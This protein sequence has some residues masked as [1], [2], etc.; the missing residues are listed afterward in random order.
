MQK[1]EGL[2]EL[3]DQQFLEGL[4][5]QLA[6]FQARLKIEIRHKMSLMKQVASL[7]KEVKQLKE[8]KDEKVPAPTPKKKVAPIKRNLI[9]DT[10]EM[11]VIPESN[12]E[13]SPMKECDENGIEK[14]AEERNTDSKLLR[15]HTFHHK[16]MPLS[17]KHGESDDEFRR[18][19]QLEWRRQVNKGRKNFLYESGHELD[20]SKGDPADEDDVLMESRFLSQSKNGGNKSTRSKGASHQIDLLEENL[21]R[22]KMTVIGNSLRVGMNVSTAGG[23]LG[24]K[25]SGEQAA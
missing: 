18:K 12:F 14:M 16:Q 20:K 7:K 9:I 19:M 21:N 15:S 13:S 6:Q 17:R 3:T 2:P 23:L 10:P 25:E 8:E 22:R 1:S 24:K 5:K 11:Q 4:K